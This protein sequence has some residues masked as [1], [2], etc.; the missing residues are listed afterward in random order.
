MGHTQSKFNMERNFGIRDSTSMRGKK[1]EIKNETNIEKKE[2]KPRVPITPKVKN[3]TKI[4]KVKKHE[5][6][7]V[8]ANKI[9]TVK[10][11]ALTPKPGERR[12]WMP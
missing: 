7:I 9:V 10:V 6:S 3:S 4:K 1:L 5:K 8:E 12:F 2:R 11:K